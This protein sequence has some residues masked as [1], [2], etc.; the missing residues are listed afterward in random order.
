MSSS[1]ICARTKCSTIAWFVDRLRQGPDTQTRSQ[2]PT[3]KKIPSRNETDNR[4]KKIWNGPWRRG[5][6]D[7]VIEYLH[8]RSHR[9]TVAT[10]ACIGGCVSWSPATLQKALESSK[11]VRCSQAIPPSRLFPEL[12]ESSLGGVGERLKPP[13][14]KTGAHT[15][16]RGFESRPLRHGRFTAPA[17]C[18][19]ASTDPL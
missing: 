18:T 16:G 10:S 11:I 6:M 3:K 5:R 19:R 2:C 7:V 9:I 8:R 1:R 4:E 12:I 15:V 17:P 14:L 13:V